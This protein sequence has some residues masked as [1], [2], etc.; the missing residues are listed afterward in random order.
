MKVK[1]KYINSDKSGEFNEVGGSS[2]IPFT[3]ADVSIWGISE[4]YFQKGNYFEIQAIKQGNKW[5]IQKLSVIEKEIPL[6][7]QQNIQKEIKNPINVKIEKKQETVIENTHIPFQNTPM[8]RN[9]YLFLNK[10]HH[11]EVGNLYTQNKSLPNNLYDKEDPKKLFDKIGLKNKQLGERKLKLEQFIFSGVDLSELKTRHLDNAKALLGEKNIDNSICLKPEWRLALGIGGASVYETS[12]T[13][14]HIY[15]IPYIPASAVKGIV[16]SWIITEYFGEKDIPDDERDFP[17][18]NAEFRAYQNENFCKIFGCP[19]DYEKIE[20]INGNPIFEMK[21]GKKKYKTK[22]FDVAL[23]NKKGEG[24]ENEGKIA[25][26]DAFPTNKINISLDIMNVHYSDYYNSQEKDENGN[27]KKGTVKPPADWSSP[28]IINFL[29]VQNTHFQFLVGA[30]NEKDLQ[31]LKIKDK[32]GQ[33]QTISFWLKDALTNHGIG[34]KT[35]VGYGY[36]Q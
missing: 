6:P 12:I 17:L 31:D 14:H 29:T 19:S 34:A 13:L 10:P 26:F 32:N 25:F 11:K 21:K 3:W 8:D 23:K 28:S 35:A 1:L 9:F 30:K 15:G 18:L 22:K 7:T 5:Q 2:Y 27:Y 36:M 20:F 4:E 33:E 16:R 24:E